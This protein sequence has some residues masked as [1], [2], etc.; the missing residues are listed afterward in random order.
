MATT[1]T[2]P[3][4]Y[5]TVTVPGTD[6][7]AIA[8]IRPNGLIVP[9][10][11]PEDFPLPDGTTNRAEGL[12]SLGYLLSV[13][14]ELPEDELLAFVDSQLAKAENWEFLRLADPESAVP[15]LE[16]DWVVGPAGRYNTE[17]IG[18]YH[19][20]I[21]LRKSFVI[22][23]MWHDDDPSLADMREALP[24]GIPLP[25]VPTNSVIA[26]SHGFELTWNGELDTMADYLQ[27]LTDAGWR[28]Q[29]PSSGSIGF[30]EHI[31]TFG[32][33]EVVVLDLGDGNFATIFNVPGIQ[34][35]PDK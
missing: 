20:G 15:G 22:Y 29:G 19:V 10:G 26:H 3:V 32:D 7:T 11:F 34:Y 17:L 31:G 24:V 1:T 12:P 2:Q 13:S 14:T 33:W 35:W 8:E 18:A 16:G 28:G 25:D 6:E 30:A 9:F 27:E 23:V 5:P 4:T 21:E